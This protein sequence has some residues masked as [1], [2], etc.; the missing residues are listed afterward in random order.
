MNVQPF[1]TFINYKV[2]SKCVC[3]LLDCLIGFQH[4][5]GV[6]LFSYQGHFKEKWTHTYSLSTHGFGD[7]LF[8]GFHPLIFLWKTLDMNSFFDELGVSKTKSPMHFNG[9]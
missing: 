5:V 6:K 9:C 1:L 3:G 8:Q 4:V 7:F 2:A